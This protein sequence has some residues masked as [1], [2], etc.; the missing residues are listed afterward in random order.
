MDNMLQ[1][2]GSNIL[3]LNKTRHCMAFDT[4]IEKNEMEMIQAY[5]DLRRQAK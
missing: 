2:D 1:H 3:T 4:G 5:Q